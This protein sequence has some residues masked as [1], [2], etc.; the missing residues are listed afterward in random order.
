MEGRDG[1]DEYSDARLQLTVSWM[2]QICNPVTDADYA[3]LGRHRD[4][5]IT[6]CSVR[7]VTRNDVARVIDTLRVTKMFKNADLV[8]D[9][10]CEGGIAIYDRKLVHSDGRPDPDGYCYKAVRFTGAESWRSVG[11]SGSNMFAAFP[12]KT[13]AEFRGSSETFVR[14]PNPDD[15]LVVR[16]SQRRRRHDVELC[17][18]ATLGA[19]KWTLPELRVVAQVLINTGAFEA[20]SRRA[21]GSFVRNKRS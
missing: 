20:H 16:R 21:L 5:L 10:A 19:P 17:C 11:S 7:P 4:A 6:I 2:E 3:A 1:V 8:P 9:P 18:K 13:V 14:F 15:G 12:G